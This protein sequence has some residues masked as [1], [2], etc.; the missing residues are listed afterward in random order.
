[1]PHGNLAVRAPSGLMTTQHLPHCKYSCGWITYGMRGMQTIRLWEVWVVHAI[2]MVRVAQG[3]LGSMGHGAWGSK[4][5]DSQKQP[6]DGCMFTCERTC[7]W[8]RARPPE[9]Y[10]HTIV[11]GGGGGASPLSLPFAC[12]LSGSHVDAFP[13]RALGPDPGR[14]RFWYIGHTRV[15][16]SPS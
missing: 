4:V 15:E 3:K 9:G 12:G 13:C 2:E 1:M 5:P 8:K 11:W 6:R 16:T 7:L 14:G 10:L